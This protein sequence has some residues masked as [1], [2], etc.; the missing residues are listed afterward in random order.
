MIEHERLDLAIARQPQDPNDESAAE[1]DP[2]LF[3]T[4]RWARDGG[5]GAHALASAALLASLKR[6]VYVLA[7]RLEFGD[8]LPG[9][10]VC[11]RPDL[12]NTSVPMKVRLGEELPSR[13]SIIHLHQVDDPEIVAAMR[14]LAPVVLSAHAYTACTSGVY[15][16]GPGQE[17]TRPHGPGCVPNLIARGC[18]HTRYPKTL[19]AKYRNATRGLEALR[20]ADIAVSYSSAVDRHLAANGIAHRAIVP[21]FP[22]MATG[23]GS[24]H[25]TRRRVVFAGRIV[26]PKGVGVLIRAAREVDGE[27]ILCGDG[28]ELDGMRELARSLGVEERVR[29]TGWL[30]A[31]QLATE[32]AEASVVVMPSLWPEPFGIVGIEAFAA[33]RPAIASATGGIED[34]LEDGVNGLSVPPADAPAL[35]G[36]L[37][38]LLADPDRQRR[39][40]LAGK[41]MVARRFSGE[42][43]V[44]A[45]LAAYRTARSRWQAQRSVAA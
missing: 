20:R 38:E 19:P 21:Y 43:H 26:R 13:P 11:H 25:Q 8:D 9:V 39:M 16:F 24:G 37:N 40:G 44:S 17:C 3:V 18:A 28:R 14:R 31:G 34:W 22:T 6:P 12:F 36:A 35:A 15:Y 42:Q 10:T 30:D 41:E 5:V 1:L 4:P 29:F 33:G 2:V 7:A 45:L 32:L 23:Q 27:F